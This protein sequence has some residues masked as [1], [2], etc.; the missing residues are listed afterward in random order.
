MDS[1]RRRRASS[2]GLP[3]EGSQTL[4]V[5]A[6]PEDYFATDDWTDRAI[7]WTKEHLGSAPGKPF[8]LYL[9]YNAP[10][11]PI[12][13]RP[14]D[15]ARYRGR[16]D[17]GWDVV[18]EQRWR[19][20]IEL[21]LL[22]AGTR[23]PPRNPGIPPWSELPPARQD[24]YA[25]YMEVYAALIDNLDS[26]IGRLIA[27]LQRAD[28]LENTV[29]VLASDNGASAMG[30]DEGAVNGWQRRLG[31]ADSDTKIQ[32]LVTQGRF[33]GPDTYMAYPRGWA[34][35]SNTPFRYFKRT[36][37][38]GGIRVPFVVHWPRKIETPG[39]IRRQW[40]HVTDVLPTLLEIA[41]IGY[42][43]EFRG[44]RT[45]SLDG[46]SFQ[47]ALTNPGAAE[48][49]TSQ[50]Y[51]LDGNRG[52]IKDGWK[53]VSLQPQDAKIDL[54][55][56]MLFDLKRDPTE[57]D[58]L[59]KA[60]P[61][62]LRELI[63]AF[64]VDAQRNHVYPIDNRGYE[65]S[66]TVPPY[67]RPV[68]DNPHTFYPGAQTA[69]RVSVFQLFA[70]RCFQVIARF[71]YRDAD[72]GVIYSIGG[73]FGGML[74]YIME[75]N[76]HFVYQRWPV[77][78]EIAP[79]PMLPGRQEVVFDFKALGKRQGVGRIILNAREVVTATPMSPTIGRLPCEGIDVGIDRRQPASARY[80][81]FG[82][83]RYTGVIDFVRVQPGPQAPGTV[84]N[85]PEPEAQ[86]RAV[87][88]HADR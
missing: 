86:K 71:E 26:N 50:H 27:F 76:L 18:R 21:G 38:N 46:V 55:N 79:V 3:F 45:R 9:A 34:Q 7:R 83:F 58:D 36:P 47:E 10:H 40:V 19:K 28:Q 57:I 78:L 43:A 12:Q 32:E 56:W 41:G 22:P 70:D 54:E 17:A 20:Q 82:T 11:M 44:Y 62:R 88:G 5:D 33:G 53:I 14:K 49:R 48:V 64:E 69:E 51:E 23:L 24:L 42:P 13:A 85:M 75:R 87:A 60:H 52:Y 72:R 31:G 66:L 1:L 8:F 35:V 15:I 84:I 65:K 67:R 30:G 39:T 16:Y 29:I 4:D 74:L 77:P 68:I 81:A 61:D 6:Y 73:L 59:S 63:D 2:S 25:R 37:V 80:A